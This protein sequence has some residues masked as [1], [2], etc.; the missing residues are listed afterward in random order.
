MT[1]RFPSKPVLGKRKRSLLSSNCNSFKMRVRNGIK[2][3]KKLRCKIVFGFDLE[4]TVTIRD[5]S[6]D[7]LKFKTSTTEVGSLKCSVLQLSKFAKFCETTTDESPGKSKRQKYS[8]NLTFQRRY[9]SMTI[10]WHRWQQLIPKLFL[11]M[12]PLRGIASICSGTVSDMRRGTEN[13][14]SV[15]QL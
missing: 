2:S 13:L 3:V 7:L 12:R 6:E 15:P 4:R 5:D 1:R 9:L 11:G 10:T 14:S 8:P